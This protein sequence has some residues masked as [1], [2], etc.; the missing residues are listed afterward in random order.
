MAV[1]PIADGYHTVAPYLI[2]DDVA[3]LIRFIERSL[4]GRKIRRMDRPDGSIMRAEVRIGDSVVMMGAATDE[5]DP[6]TAMLHLYVDDVD[7]VYD[8]AL[9][10]GAESLR[11]P[12][13]EF[14]G[15]RMAG[16]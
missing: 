1:Q 7:A 2:V 12:T 3:R 13:D 9:E 14:Y 8:R 5:H 4:A 11:V 15:D 10:A 16:V 6:V